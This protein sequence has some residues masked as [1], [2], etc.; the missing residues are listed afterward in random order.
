M[1]LPSAVVARWSSLLL[2]LYDLSWVGQPAFEV[3]LL[4]AN[5]DAGLEACALSTSSAFSSADK[6]SVGAKSASVCRVIFWLL[7]PDI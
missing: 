4:L 5:L 2:T 1:S 3:L 6:T 7:P